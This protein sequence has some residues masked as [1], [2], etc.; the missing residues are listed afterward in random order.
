MTNLKAFGQFSPF[1]VGFDEIFN[2]L[3]RASIPQ[4]NYP[5]Y[6]IL[7][8]DDKYIIR[9]AIAGFKKSEVDI[10]LDDNTLTVSVCRE[11]NTGKQRAEF[12]H[13]GISSK[14]FYKSF[15]L[16]EHVEVKKA[17]M[18]DGILRIMLEKNIP[19]NERPKKIKIS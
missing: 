1:S 11:D 17:T 13:K 7:K 16:A 9:I 4:S 6:D 19:E 15:A 18:S 2:T 14:E 3:H 5:P 10:E 12:L 8:E